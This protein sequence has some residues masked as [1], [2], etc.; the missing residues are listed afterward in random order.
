MEGKQILSVTMSESSALIHPELPRDLAEAQAQAI[1]A[2]QTAIQAGYTRVMVEIR[3]P[4][5]ELK[6]EILAQPFLTLLDPPFSLLFS[7][8]GAAAL[9]QREWQGQDLDL[10]GITL[11][12]ISARSVVSQEMGLIFLLPAVSTLDTV[13][14]ICRV[15][16]KGEQQPR[17]VVLINPQLQDAASVGV[18]LAGRRFRERFITTF[19]PCYY[20]RPLASGALLRIYPHPWTVW[21]EME[22][23]DYRL[24][25]TVDHQP[26][27]EEL[28]EIFAADSD[29][30]AAWLDSLRRFFQAL[31]R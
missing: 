6:P 12:G 4:E 11:Q 15:V 28:A 1:Q 24:L 18:G 9:A 27:G 29:Q 20:L 13:E 21:A 16:S 19:E 30:P 14:Q 17:P 7:D 22:D 23:G 10:E 3:V 31:R 25:Q 8:A 26:D 5:V 2:V